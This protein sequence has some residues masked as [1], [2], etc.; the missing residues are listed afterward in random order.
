MIYV[1][2]VEPEYQH[3][4]SDVPDS[5]ILIQMQMWN[6]VKGEIENIVSFDS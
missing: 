3:E 1:K 4:S 5:P 6:K 2:R